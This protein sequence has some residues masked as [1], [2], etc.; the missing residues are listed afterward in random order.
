MVFNNFIKRRLSSLL[1][2][3]LEQDL[4]L[5]LQ[6]GFINSIAIA[7][8]LRLDTSDLNRKLI[9]GSSS[10][11]FFFKEFVIEEFVVRFSN[12]SA[13]AFTFE[14]RGVKVTLSYE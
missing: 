5:D 6:L 7:K 4:E 8:N 11:R 13:S 14:A 3:W 12:W 10:S 2:P 9:D 1:R